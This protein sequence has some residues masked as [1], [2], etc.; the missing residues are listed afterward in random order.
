[1]R[2]KPFNMELILASVL[3]VRMHGGERPAQHLA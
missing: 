2:G 1:M 3:T